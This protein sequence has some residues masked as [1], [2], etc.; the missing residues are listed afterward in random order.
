[1][2]KD[3]VSNPAPFLVMATIPSSEAKAAD[4][5]THLGLFEQKI[6]GYPAH[7]DDKPIRDACKSIGDDLFR[8]RHK[9]VA[10]RPAEPN[11][12]RHKEILIDTAKVNITQ[13]GSPLPWGSWA[14]SEAIA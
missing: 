1:M 9:I 4:V 13:S 7:A 6:P 5:F 14:F 3:H 11:L 12:V 2:E 8:T 10:V